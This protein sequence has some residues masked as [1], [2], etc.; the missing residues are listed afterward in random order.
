[1]FL[2]CCCL[3][4]C[5]TVIYGL[6]HR[7]L[8]YRAHAHAIYIGVWH[9]LRDGRS[10]KRHFFILFKRIYAQVCDELT[11]FCNISSAFPKNTTCS[12][13]SR[14]TPVKLFRREIIRQELETLLAQN[15]ASE[16]HI[17]FFYQW[18]ISALVGAA[19]AVCLRCIG[20]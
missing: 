18:R 3:S 13:I 14:I 17:Y 9:I 11:R 2:L 8:S 16:R 5:L 15:N 1:M 10:A 7:R 12:Q 20:A 6:L 4:D 19:A